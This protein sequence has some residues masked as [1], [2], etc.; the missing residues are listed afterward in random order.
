[1]TA[2]QAAVATSYDRI[3]ERYL[4]WS[5]PATARLD[6][7]E[8]LLARLPEAAE[9]LDL[10]CGAGTPIAA[11]LAAAGHRVTGVDLS[12][13]QI[14]LAR[15]AV[16][17]GR[18]IQGDM[19]EIDLAEASLDAVVAAYSLI[20]LPRERHAAQ[21]ARIRG[22]LRPGGLLLISLGRG[23][24][25]GGEQAFLGADVFFSHYDA[26][27][28][29]GLIAKAGFQTLAARDIPERAGPSETFHWVLAQAEEPTP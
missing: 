24:V 16:P 3:A 21:L 5:A 4:D 19:A 22:W 23:D 15:E 1:M 18:F 27:T 20:H 12:A 14:A 26:P 7:L 13:R 9:V 11:R 25:P 8:I 28:T 10:G 2:P 29:K 17:T 6:A